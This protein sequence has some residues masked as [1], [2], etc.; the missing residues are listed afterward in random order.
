MGVT[1]WA[2]LLSVVLLGTAAQLALK[3]A[4]DR[5]SQVHS[6]MRGGLSRSPFAWTWFICYTI[7]TI[8]WLLALRT[9]PLTQA[10]PILGLQFALVPLASNVLLKERV[11]WEQWLGIGIITAG[12]AVVGAG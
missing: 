1:A 8:L 3:H 7:S 4:L 5:L 6:T 10:F 9:I 12:V 11:C 2:H